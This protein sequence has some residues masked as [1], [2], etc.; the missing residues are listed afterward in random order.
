MIDLTGGWRGDYFRV[1]ASVDDY[2]KLFNPANGLLQTDRLGTTGR[3][4]FVN[5]SRDF[6]PGRLSQGSFDIA[7][8]HRT[9]DDGRTQRSNLYIGGSLEWNQFALT[10]LSFFDGDYRPETGDA[11]G[12]YGDTVN[13]DRYWTASVDLNT[14]GDRFGSGASISDG[15]LGGE[16]YGYLIGYL[17]ARPTANTSLSVVAERLESFGTYKQ[18]II[19]AGWDIN[20][21]NAMV[22]RHVHS[23]G[24][25]Y[26]RVGYRRVVSEGLDV[27]FLTDKAPQQDAQVS[28]KLLWL[29]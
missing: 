16:D 19:E 22:F 13:H 12:D 11:P 6:G 17:W 1:G 23:S 4:A 5:F 7:R 27:F 10:S 2:D 14:R 3:S 26:W 29:L 9:T 8:S 28:V 21:T 15:E 25:A 18:Y 20:P 24:D